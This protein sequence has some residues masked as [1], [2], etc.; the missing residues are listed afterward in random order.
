[1]MLGLIYLHNWVILFGLMLIN[2]SYME[3]MGYDDVGFTENV[4]K[5]KRSIMIMDHR[6]RT[7]MRTIVLGLSYLHSWVI[8][9]ATVGKYSE[10]GAHGVCLCLCCFHGESAWANKTRTL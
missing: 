7:H 10:H 9:R 6:S 8:F 5:N 1:M 4:G 3:N 2:I